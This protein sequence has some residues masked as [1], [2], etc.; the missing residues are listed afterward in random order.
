MSIHC[1]SIPSRFT[2]CPGLLLQASSNFAL[3]HV[4]LQLI[5]SV[6]RL[7]TADCTAVHTV[8]FSCFTT[9]SH[10]ASVNTSWQSSPS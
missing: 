9:Q 3:P 6:P 7:V 8:A 4:M 1:H 5:L 10:M 2:G